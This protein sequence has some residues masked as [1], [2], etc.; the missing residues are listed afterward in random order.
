MAKPNMT[1]LV[2]P[3][4]EAVFWMD[5]FGR[6]H[7]EHGP[8]EHKKIIDHFNASI[9][10]DDSG[11]FVGQERDDLYEKVYFRYED[12]PIFVVDIRLGDSIEVILNTMQRMVLNPDDLYVKND[13]LYIQREDEHIR[14]TDRVLLKLSGRLG[15]EEDKYYFEVDGN[16]QII[17][18]KH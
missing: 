6:W 9:R 18:E 15:Y 16:R 8:F 12:T 11:Y 17:P 13:N 5:R 1:E 14:F 10:K 3:K 2:I 4:E 7:N